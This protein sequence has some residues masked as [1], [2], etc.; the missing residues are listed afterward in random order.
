MTIG[1]YK[2]EHIK[3]G[4]KYIGSSKKVE[5]RLH[6]HLRLLRRKK[7]HNIY[8]QKTWNKYGENSFQLGLIVECSFKDLSFY[9]D[10]IIKGYKSNQ[11]SSGYNIRDVS[12][13]NKGT[14]TKRSFQHIGKTFNRLTFIRP[15]TRI[16]TT[17]THYWQCRCSCGVVKD[18]IGS[19]VRTGH[20]KSC[21]CLN[22]ERLS[23]RIT[24]WN[25]DNPEIVMKRI[26]ELHIKYPE[27]HN[28]KN[29]SQGIP[30]QQ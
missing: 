9:E 15:S 30:Q 27:P 12:F 25:R 1:I 16:D 21:G 8:L 28:K 7:H 17:G 22:K 20:S 10:L 19:D 3:S 23:E 5:T 14:L 13:S 26:E 29:K 11:R 6:E 4:K 18:F 24:K 2:I